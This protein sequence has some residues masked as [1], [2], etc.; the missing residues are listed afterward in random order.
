MQALLNLDPIFWVLIIF[1]IAAL[2][3]SILKAWQWFRLQ[4]TFSNKATVKVQAMLASDSTL[5]QPVEDK[6]NLR[7]ALLTQYAAAKARLQLKGA[8]LETEA[9][10]IAR[11][12]VDKLGSYLK[13]LE[14]VATVAPLIGLLGT[15]LGM[16]EAFKAM[17][18]AGA[19][20][21]PAVLSG[22]IWKALSTTAAGLIVAIPAF[23]IHSWFDRKTEKAAAVLQNDLELF[24]AHTSNK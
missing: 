18:L 9:W 5:S 1:S 24:L 11:I 6:K 8:A 22:G 10:R 13:V 4:V 14:V 19:N 7:I 12:E 3:V 20:V 2:S 15:V 17:E 16:V 21:D 23:I